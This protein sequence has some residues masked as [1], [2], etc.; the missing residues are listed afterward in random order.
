MRQIPE[1]WNG[2]QQD[3][4]QNGE[5]NSLVKLISV[6]NIIKFSQSV[7][8]TKNFIL[9]DLN[10]QFEF[11]AER[12]AFYTFRSTSYRFDRMISLHAK[13]AIMQSWVITFLG[14]KNECTSM[15]P[16]K[17][18]NQKCRYSLHYCTVTHLLRKIALYWEFS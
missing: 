2:S 1:N 3:N 14:G 16:K 12:T 9:R 17:C 6:N 11:P 8:L 13:V 18:C 10:F 7:Q 5:N 4:S 15:F